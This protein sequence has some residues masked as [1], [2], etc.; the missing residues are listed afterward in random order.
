MNL[1]ITEKGT[2]ISLKNNKIIIRNSDAEK[3]IPIGMIKSLAIGRNVQMTSQ[4]ICTLSEEGIDIA[5]ISAG[6]LVCRTYGNENV[7][8]QKYQFDFLNN[9]TLTLMLA[10]RNIIA[11]IR[12]QLDFVG[13]SVLFNSADVKKCNSI[14]ELFGVEGKYASIYFKELKK[15]IP[16]KYGF[17]GRNK[18]QPDDIVN[19]LMNYCYTILYNKISEILSVHGLNPSIGIMHTLKNGHY[20]L[21]SDLMESL[22][23]YVCDEA[24]L[25]LLDEGVEEDEIIKSVKGVR[26]SKEMRYRL[27]TQFYDV[28][29]TEI[30][31]ENG[32]ANNYNGIIEKMICSYIKAI[33]NGDSSLFEPF[34]KDNYD[35]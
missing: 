1:Y 29:E 23:S 16:D 30:E 2:M 34:R 21:S 11:K 12:N 28:L 8:R 26:L 13:K 32:F 17:N 15:E 25:R 24:V 14:E 9:V 18:F 4:A 35:F 10:K 33:E 5:W 7:I 20:A 3:E 6:K 22:R 27:I 31:T 19:S